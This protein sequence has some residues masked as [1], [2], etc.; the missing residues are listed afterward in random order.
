[1]PEDNLVKNTGIIVAYPEPTDFIVSGESGIKYKEVLPSGDWTP[2]LPTKEPQFLNFETFSCVSF[3]A[4]NMIET[5]IN[6]LVANNLIPQDKLK[7]MRDWG[8]FDANNKFNCSDR[9]TAKMSGTTKV[10]NTLKAVWDSI[11]NNGLVP[12]A[13]WSAKNL[14]S[15]EE[16]MAEIPGSIKNFAKNILS[17]LDF[18]YEWVVVGNCGAPDL[19]LIRKHLKHA[20]MQTARPSCPKDANGVMQ[21]CGTCEPAHATMLRGSE[22]YNLEF[23]SYE[24]YTRNL[25]LNFPIPF[26]MKGLVSIKQI[27]VV[28]IPIPFGHIFTKQISFGERSEEVRWLQKGLIRLGFKTFETGYYGEWTRLAVKAFQTKYQ[29]ASLEDINYINGRWTGSKTRAKL[30]ELLA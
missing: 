2:Y 24:P 21:G 9:F 22:V 18:N 30:N 10:G 5:Q 4:H 7:L 13:M 26:L 1:M 29:L 16:Y 25:A 17:I 28:P 20:P 8:F 27:V 3:S 23:D 6:Y 15:W 11:N 12:E 19:A 14:N